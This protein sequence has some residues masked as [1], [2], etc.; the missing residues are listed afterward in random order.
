MH[1]WHNSKLKYNL[2]LSMDAIKHSS[3]SDG[4]GEIGALLPEALL[5]RIE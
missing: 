1:R 5:H 4:R 2:L 3:F